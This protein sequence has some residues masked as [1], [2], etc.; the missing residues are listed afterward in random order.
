MCVS[1]K[2]RLYAITRPLLIIDD[3]RGVHSDQ[4]IRHGTW[5]HWF[6]YLCKTCPAVCSGEEN[7][8]S[9]LLFDTTP[10]LSKYEEAVRNLH[11][12]N[13][14][15]TTVVARVTTAVLI[16]AQKIRR[17]ESSPFE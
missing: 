9:A 11:L 4:Y 14:K 17:L 1:T 6:G 8:F 10:P 5:P 16:S 15:I 3:M 12:K 13:F 7:L 2:K